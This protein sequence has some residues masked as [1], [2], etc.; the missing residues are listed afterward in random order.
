ML[1]RDECDR[2]RGTLGNPGLWPAVL[3]SRP[4]RG[5]APAPGLRVASGG[6]V[7]NG[8]CTQVWGPCYHRC[9]HTSKLR[10][11][12]FL[13]R[14]DVA[15][16][17]SGDSLATCTLGKGVFARTSV[18]LHSAPARRALCLVPSG[19]SG[20]A[21]QLCFQGARPPPHPGPRHPGSVRAGAWLG[22][23]EPQD[24]L[25]TLRGPRRPRQGLLSPHT[26]HTGGEAPGVQRSGPPSRWCQDPVRPRMWV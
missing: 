23:P 2:G 4:S 22:L 1:N 6:T 19:S 26:R 20:P 15:S 25:L 10:P 3:A 13:P 8:A 5:S 21:A 16:D 17:S 9:V 14:K 12:R 24:P 11:R 18:T 7:R